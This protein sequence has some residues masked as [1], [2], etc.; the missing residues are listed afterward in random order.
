MASSPALTV[1]INKP[2]SRAGD[3]S[4]N[5]FL[6]SGQGCGGWGRARFRRL[7]VATFLDVEACWE[8]S[9]VSAM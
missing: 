1:S 5:R 7:L 4:G 2:L 6:I 8:D 9:A 3:T